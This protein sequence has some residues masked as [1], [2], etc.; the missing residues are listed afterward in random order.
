MPILNSIFL[1]FLY[2]YWTRIFTNVD[3]VSKGFYP[4]GLLSNCLYFFYLIFRRSQR[5]L[6]LSRK[7]NR[8]ELVPK[9]HFDLFNVELSRNE[10]SFSS[11]CCSLTSNGSILSAKCSSVNLPKPAARVDNSGNST[12]RLR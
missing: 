8:S 3:K 6:N 2:F 4:C 7:E 9:S 12:E 10:T 5:S 11:S 1:N